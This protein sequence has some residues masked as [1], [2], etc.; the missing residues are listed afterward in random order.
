MAITYFQISDQN[1]PVSECR[2]I[3][4]WYEKM[5]HNFPQFK[6]YVCTVHLHFYEGKQFLGLSVCF[7]GQ[8]SPFK[9]GSILKG[10]NLLLG[11]QILYL[12]VDP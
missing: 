8:G 11:E 3:F 1:L 10:K 6:L 9:I 5:Q 2:N 12:R 7:P 4:L